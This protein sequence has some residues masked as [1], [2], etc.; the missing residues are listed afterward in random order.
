M[1]RLKDPLFH[2]GW[3][4]FNEEYWGLRSELIELGPT[5]GTSWEAKVVLYENSKGQIVMPPRNPHIPFDFYS[6]SNKPS[7]YNRRKR[8]AIE[9]L[10]SR[11]SNKSV[12]GGISLSSVVND[13]RPFIWSNMIAE[14][15]YTFYLDISNFKKRLD[16]SVRNKSSKAMGLGYTCEI[17][18]DYA[19]VQSCLAG[20]AARK[21]FSHN[22]SQDGLSRLAELMGENFVCYLA[23]NSKGE[24]V[25]AWVRV[26]ES[27]GMALG[28]S[29]G[30]KTQAL[31]DGVNSLLGEYSLEH[32]SSKGCK[33]FDFVGANIP[34]VSNMKEAWGGDLVCYHSVRQNSIRNLARSAVLYAKHKMKD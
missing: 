13:V 6:A 17:T 34:S 5:R 14:P 1:D 3:V 16:S 7:S 32:L 28:W 18:Y 33:V 8:N 2:S 20:P 21:G 24:P 22:V 12:K 30:V 10:A 19:A 23:R 29:A 4:G 27:G 9:L 25:G 15:R 31:R 26:F 11:M